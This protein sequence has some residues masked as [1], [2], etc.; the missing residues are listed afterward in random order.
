MYEL[1][2]SLVFTI[3]KS[4]T[5][6]FKID[7]GCLIFYVGPKRR[8]LLKFKRYFLDKS[9]YLK[10]LP[11]SCHNWSQIDVTKRCALFRE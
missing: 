1:Q 9:R 10:I 6:N 3:K 11:E 7:T 5:I 4:N 8:F 2:Q